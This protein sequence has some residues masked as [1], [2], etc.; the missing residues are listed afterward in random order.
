M[1]TRRVDAAIDALWTCRDR[2]PF[3]CEQYRPETPERAA[4]EDV[5]AAVRR[6]DEALLGRSA[7]PPEAAV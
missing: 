3:L 5:L 7:R 2:L 6:A 1:L 4:L